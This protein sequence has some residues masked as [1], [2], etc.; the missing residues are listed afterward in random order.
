MSVAGPI[1]IYIG[2]PEEYFQEAAELFYDS[3]KQ[4][5]NPIMNTREQGISFLLKH[6]NPKGIM[7]ASRGKE[8]LGIAGLQHEGC[9]F[10]SPSAS[11][12]ARE[13]GWLRSITKTLRMRL[14]N[15]TDR[16]GELYLKAVMVHS[17]MQG[18]GVG[19]HLLT[20]IS[21]F[22]WA[23]DFNTIRLDV[24]DTNPDA[25]RFYEQNGFV[26]TKIRRCPLPFQFLC[27]EMGFSSAITMIKKIS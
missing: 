11:D 26:A 5:F 7:V 18:R 2:L 25:R 10:F 6:L 21:D 8:L 27:R 24:V 15:T 14:F 3:F 17:E 9:H 1:E 4:K 12:L 16:K 13:F 20:G 23:H 22:A 19:T